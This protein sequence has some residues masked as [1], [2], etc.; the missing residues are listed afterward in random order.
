M[1]ARPSNPVLF[2]AFLAAL[3]ALTQSGVAADT[4][5]PASTQLTTPPQL[6][7][8]QPNLDHYF[9]KNQERDALVYV[10][11][12]LKAD[13]K[14][15]NA[16]VAPGGFY[17]SRFRSAALQMITRLRFVPAMVDGTP[18]DYAGALMPI[19]FRGGQG[20]VQG[21]TQEFRKEARKVQQLIEEKDLAG[22]H[23]HA[24]WMLSEKVRLAFEFAVLQATMAD[25][26]ARTGNLHRA[27][28]A[29]QEI[30]ARTN[31]RIAAF[32]PGGPLPEVDERDYLITR[33]MLNSMLR[34]RFGLAASQGLYLDAVR[35]HADLQALKLVSADDPSFNTFAKLMQALRTEPELRGHVVIGET[36]YWS[37]DLWFRHFTVQNVRNGALRGI[38]LACADYRREIPYA[39]D[40]EWN[41]PSRWEGCKA[42]FSASAGT[43]FDI[44]E[45]RERSAPGSGPGS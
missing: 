31:L 22:A 29:T 2:L 8:V 5:R 17:D 43:E 45:Y 9:P 4:A 42:G 28:S 12:D 19:R 6:E 36:E 7:K 18:V 10:R 14:V 13:G 25:T 44:V 30:T 40:V 16:D 37:Q 24:Q 35:A 11:F 27:L 38:R 26:Y 1:R 34:L 23:H 41:V 39:P 21:V 15:I 32:Q 20:P 33:D 3:A